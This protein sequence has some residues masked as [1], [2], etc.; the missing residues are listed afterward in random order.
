MGLWARKPSPLLALRPILTFAAH[1]APNEL[2]AALISFRM[3]AHLSAFSLG[4]RLSSWRFAEKIHRNRRVLDA[5]D[6][7][8]LR[9]RWRAQVHAVAGAGLHERISQRR[10]PARSE[11]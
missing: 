3:K 10:A 4:R 2:L 5:D 11:E 7:E 6:L 1:R 8:T 9:L